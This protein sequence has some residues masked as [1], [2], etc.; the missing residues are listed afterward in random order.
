MILKATQVGV[1]SQ[2]TPTS[3][4]QAAIVVAL[5]ACSPGPTWQLLSWHPMKCPMLQYLPPTSAPAQAGG[6]AGAATAWVGG[7]SGNTSSAVSPFPTGM[8][9]PMMS[10]PLPFFCGS[11][12]GVSHITFMPPLVGPAAAA[13]AAFKAAQATAAVMSIIAGLP[14]CGGGG[15]GVTQW[16]CVCAQ[17]GRHGGRE[18]ARRAT[19]D[20]RT[21]EG[22]PPSQGTRLSGGNL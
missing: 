17:W 10:W 7:T 19:A 1:L 11:T 20:V 3:S 12:V 2:A 21:S 6:G 22:P 8:P 16:H 18:L 9:P 14:K 5:H 13:C 4:T 15:G